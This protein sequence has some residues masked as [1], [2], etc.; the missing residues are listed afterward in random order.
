MVMRAWALFRYNSPYKLNAI[1]S[2]HASVKTSR[3][4]L[5]LRNCGIAR[6]G[7]F[8]TEKTPSL[9]VHGA[10]AGVEAQEWRCDR[11]TAQEW[12]HAT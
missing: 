12:R 3:I 11:S 9:P 1:Y 6:R 7:A 4:S 5:Q 10:G 2:G 8:L